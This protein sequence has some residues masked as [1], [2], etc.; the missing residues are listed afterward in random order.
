MKSRFCAR[1]EW[2]EAEDPL[3]RRLR[4]AELELRVARQQSCPSVEPL[5]VQETDHRGDQA[6]TSVRTRL[7]HRRNL[8]NIRPG[9][10][11]FCEIASPSREDEIVMSEAH[12]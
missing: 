5:S 9:A 3:R 11:N 10:L 8:F 2:R 4:G 1:S 6:D 12:E 7:H